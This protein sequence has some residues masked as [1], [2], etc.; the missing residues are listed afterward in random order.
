[1]YLVKNFFIYLFLA[2]FP[3]SLYGLTYEAYFNKSPDNDAL[4]TI[5]IN[6][7]NSLPNSSRIEMCI[8]D[9]DRSNIVSTLT[10]IAND[11]SITINM[12]VEK[13]NANSSTAL[14]DAQANIT[15][16]SDENS[17]LM[18]NK[19]IIFDYNGGSALANM[20]WTGSLNLTDNGI[21]KNAQNIIIL[22]NQTLASEFSNEFYQMFTGDNYG[23]AKTAHSTK[24]F[25]IEGSTIEA[26]FSPKDNPSSRLV[27]LIN[28]AKHT[29]YFSIFSGTDTDVIDALISKF[30]QGID[31][32]GVCDG[33]AGAN[34]GASGIYTKSVAAG[35]PIYEDKVDNQADSGYYLLHHK[36]MIIDYGYVTSDP[37]VVTG[38]YNWTGAGNDDNDENMLVIHNNDVAKE[39]F[40]EFRERIQ[41]AGGPV[42]DD[43]ALLDPPEEITRFEAYPVYPHYIQIKWINPVDSDFDRVVIRYSTSE[44]VTDPS[45]GY[46]V[47][48]VSGASGESGELTLSANLVKHQRYYLTAFVYD[49]FGNY[50]KV[51]TSCVFFSPKVQGGIADNFIKPD[52]YNKVEIYFNQTAPDNI[53]IYNLHGRLVKKINNIYSQKIEWDLKN[54]YG[55]DVGSG[56]YFFVYNIN[57]EIVREKVLIAR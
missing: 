19:F 45:L 55:Y 49:R 4:D 23:T 32:R 26:Y 38:S 47:G 6:K 8:Y 42:P 11:K 33:W 31:V 3:L 25:T 28:S 56:I 7:L 40:Y 1:M 37:L 18:H 46:N 35:L 41:E 30:N 44:F 21:D 10:N 36:Y 27:Q 16:K 22:Q 5:L 43:P 9:I 24:S 20:I 14:L 48:T 52:D 15:V 57:G 29:I 2:L 34:Y 12:V 54:D 13:D 51:Y 50:S 39:Y 17:A 53:E